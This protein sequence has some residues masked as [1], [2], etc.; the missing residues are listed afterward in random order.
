MRKV[1]D[2]F[3]F[4]DEILGEDQYGKVCKAQQAHDLLQNVN[5][6][7]SKQKTIRPTADTTK[8]IYAC[9]V[10]KTEDWHPEDL[11]DIHKEVQLHGMVLSRHFIRLHQVIKTDEN[12]Y[13]IQEYANGL[14]LADLLEA[15]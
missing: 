1:N 11:S 9:K 12:M 10:I 8:K 4:V 6:D 7:G 2:Y 15:K 3:V 13:M 14:D 5:G